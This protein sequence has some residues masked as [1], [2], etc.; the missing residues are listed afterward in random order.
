[1]DESVRLARK[2]NTSP[3][4]N[5]RFGRLVALW[6]S[7]TNIDQYKKSKNYRKYFKCIC[8]CNQLTIV[9][10]NSLVSGN[11]K[12]CG[13]LEKET[14]KK[15]NTK[16][17]KSKTREHNIW[18]GLKQR[19]LNKKNNHYKNYGARG[20]LI[21]QKW[22]YSFESFI[23][24]VGIAPSKNHSLDR[25][26]N[27]GN[28]EPGN[29]RWAT[30]E[31]QNNN[32]RRTIFLELNGERKSLADWCYK[33]NLKRKTVYARIRSGKSVEQALDLSP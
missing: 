5:K 21:S 30:R 26:N 27:D 15:V 14:V 13:C 28:Y 19:C 3:I 22:L 1:M 12:S 11:T 29:C 7:H 8:D 17:G 24:D 9:E 4:E 25:I 32:S 20:I 23:L 31:E 2:Y 6:H 18:S 33:F 10:R 16:H